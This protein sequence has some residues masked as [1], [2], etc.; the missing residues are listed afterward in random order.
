MNWDEFNKSVIDNYIKYINNHKLLANQ[1]IKECI[2]K[3]NKKVL[4]YN[5]YIIYTFKKWSKNLSKGNGRLDP[6]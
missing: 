5:K 4:C 2:R 6:I 1:S 3:Q